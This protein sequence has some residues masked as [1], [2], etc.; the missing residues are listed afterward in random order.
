MAVAIVG[1]GLPGAGKSTRLK[2]KAEG[3]GAVYICAD[4]IRAELYGDASE[5]HDPGYVWGVAHN[6]IREALKSGR[7]VVVDGTFVKR[8][9]RIQMF[10]VCSEAGAELIELIWF[11]ASPQL[12][13][14]RNMRRER[15][16]PPHVIQRM[17]RQ[18]RDE[19]P[20]AELEGFNSL[21]LVSTTGLV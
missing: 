4:D 8:R 20:D 15:N 5:Q 1:M 17:S 13:T 7:D 18:I 14:A 19:L 3:M 11:Q 21:E 10:R 9:D 12:C 2:P 6:R 16:V